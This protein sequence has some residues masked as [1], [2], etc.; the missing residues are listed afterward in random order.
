MREL[1]Q[2]RE[3]VHLF[4]PLEIGKMGLKN[5]IVMAPMVTNYAAEDGAATQRLIDYLVAR[6][7]GG[8][9][10]IEVEA[11]YVR[12]DGKGFSHELGIYKDEL[13]PGLQE[14]T[15]RLHEAG[16]RVAMQIFHAGRQTSVAVTG[17]RPVAP[18]ALV[19]PSSGE[20]PRELTIEEILELE[21]AFAQAARRV[22]EAGFDAVEI[23][24]AHGYLIGEFLS[25]FSNRR[26]DEYG[27]SLAGRMRF[28]LQIVR[29]VRQAVGGGYPILFRLSADEYVPGGL[30][31]TQSQ[32]I[33][34]AVQD[35]G[36]DAISVSAANNATPGMNIAPVMELERALFVPLAQDIKEVVSVPVIAVGRLHDPAIADQGLAKGQADL[37][38]LGRALL[39]DPDWVE[40]AERG[41]V[42][43][44]R[45]CI[46]CNQACIDYLLADEPISCLLN[47]ACGREREFAISPAPEPKRVVVVGGG[48]GGLE[49]T[50]VLAERGHRV[51]LFEEDPRLGGEFTVAARAPRKEELSDAL[52]WLIHQVQQSEADVRLGVRATADQ[53]LALHPDAVIVATGGRPRIPAL[54]GLEPERAV[55]ARDVLIGEAMP[56]EQVLVAGGGQVGIETAAYLSLANKKVTVVEMASAPAIDMNPGRRYWVLE[57]LAQRGVSIQTDTT[58]EAVNDGSVQ[59]SHE[60]QKETL[61]PFDDLVLALGYE[62]NAEL[63]SELEGR[64]PAVYTIGDAAAVRTA[65]EAIREGAEVARQI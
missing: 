49:A 17:V 29:K 56:C 41:E 7:R 8:V 38:A 30:D 48:P 4:L 15:R 28:A 22:K 20:V 45:P 57:E 33:A 37:V 50:R 59:V 2:M 19:E 34:A 25:P 52:R 27:G 62:P 42:E 3:L 65:V 13:I 12:P 44:I 55:F 23:H 1:T 64:V 36:A 54:H 31:L 21:E 58:I 60:G 53:V 11:S 61:G 43:E 51:T 40:K 39:T 6:A 18:S 47:P 5:R 16:A 10:L 14:L 35:V 46:S 32:A 9:G 26:D 63:A 24:G